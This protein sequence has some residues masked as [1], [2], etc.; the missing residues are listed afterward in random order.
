MG[1]DGPRCICDTKP[2]AF[3]GTEENGKFKPK[4]RT[5][6]NPACCFFFLA[7]MG[8][9]VFVIAWSFV[10]GDKYLNQLKHGIDYSGN[11]CGISVGFEEKKYL[12][13]CGTNDWE[14]DSPFPK[15]LN[16][17]SKTCVEKCP[18]SKTDM[19]DC[20]SHQMVD[21]R[22]KGVPMTMGT[23]ESKITYLNTLFLEITQSVTKQKGYPS[24][25]IEGT[26]CVP[27]TDGLDAATQ[28][29]FITLGD[30][31]KNGL[32]GGPLLEKVRIATA[33]ASFW[34]GWWIV[35]VGIVLTVIVS[36]F[37]LSALRFYAG[38]VILMTM[39]ACIGV[40]LI[41]GLFFVFGI[42]IDSSKTQDFYN[43]L[44]PIFCL[45]NTLEANF[46][47]LIVGIV[48]LAC[49]VCLMF[50]IQSQKIDE[51]MGIVDAAAQAMWSNWWTFLGQ[52]IIGSLIMTALGIFLL[53][54]YFLATTVRT[55]NTGL[56]AIE[57]ETTYQNGAGQA[58]AIGGLQSKYE[59]AWWWEIALKVYC[60]GAV[61]LML[62]A[63]AIGNFMASFTVCSYFFTEGQEIQTKEAKDLGKLV[64]NVMND[65]GDQKKI[66]N[67][68]LKNAGGDEGPRTGYRE[69]IDGQKFIVV[70]VGPVLP[71]GKEFN[72]LDETVVEKD[73]GVAV[74][75]WVRGLRAAILYH[76]GSLALGAWANTLTEPFRT[77]SMI[78]KSF[79]GDSASYL[80]EETDCKSILRGGCA[81][82]AAVLDD[83][84]GMFS[85]TMYSEIV[86]SSDYMMP[87]AKRVND[88]VGQAGGN[89]A[90]LHGASALYEWIA[91]IMITGFVTLVTFIIAQVLF[92]SNEQVSVGLIVFLTS[93]LSFLIS[94]LFMSLLD[95]TCN[96][97]LYSFAWARKF[98]GGDCYNRNADKTGPTD[99]KI[100][101]TDMRYLMGK[102]LD[103]APKDAL[104]PQGKAFRQNKHAHAAAKYQQTLRKAWAETNFQRPGGLMESLPLLGKSGP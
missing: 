17:M 69:T 42:F 100:I 5:L 92:G 38:V 71:S 67:I 72:Q 27:K 70:P 75:T 6:T 101:P 18:T 1:G 3:P 40:M 4:D 55:L 79:V 49:S 57:D 39:V 81:L 88:F 48:F 22:D 56:I 68:Q 23:G 24:Q 64:K 102:E 51:T 82:T 89:V 93:V 13:F 14:T 11:I 34:G 15:Q 62:M 25:E 77:L 46:L 96:S 66:S 36:C 2:A 60:L 85:K 80:D 87:S 16:Y 94:S 41:L 32:E 103:I 8:V 86:L 31:L 95:T 35:V 61:W 73:M 9:L 104:K 63:L 20:L 29:A 91:V 28:G 10:E 21:F 98:H 12:Y 76:L 52:P 59:K 97:L 45:N 53:Y 65:P 37:Y 47:S 26:Y 90:V 44:N 99:Y 33:T 7:V 84:F 50:N 19:V 54:G 43:L 30:E 83:T 58:E 78:L 74:A